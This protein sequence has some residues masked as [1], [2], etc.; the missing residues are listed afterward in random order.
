MLGI[1]DGGC[2]IL[3]GT[4]VVQIHGCV[5]LG[6][7]VEVQNELLIQ[8]LLQKFQSCTVEFALHWV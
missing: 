5:G 4:L 2:N 6:G 8:S 1:D 7:V 3:A